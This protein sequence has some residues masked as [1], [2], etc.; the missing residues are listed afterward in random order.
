[1]E[2]EYYGTAVGYPASKAT[3]EPPQPALSR[4]YGAVDR[5]GK[6][7]SSLSDISDRLCGGHPNVS[8]SGE[9]P[10]PN[11][12]FDEVEFLAGQIINMADRILADTGRISN[13][14]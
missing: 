1:M 2:K 7:A 10:A 6:A 12:V 8:A 3:L 5:L 14:L 4:L 13:R 11:G 9:A